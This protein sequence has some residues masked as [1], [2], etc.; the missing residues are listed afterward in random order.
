MNPNQKPWTK[1]EFGKK[2]SWVARM[3][4]TIDPD[5]V[6]LQE[7]WHAE[8]METVLARAALRDRYD[9]L[10]KP[11][12]GSKIV[13]AALV[14]KGLLRGTP[15]W[16]STFPKA[17]RL[18]STRRCGSTPRTAWTRSPRASAC[19]SPGSHGRCCTSRSRCAT[20]RRAPRCSWRT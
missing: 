17:V 18:D 8:A 13:C 5:I 6:G 15:K 3:L 10:A 4:D 20:T 16:I 14:R 9:L 19:T 1:E 2:V 12:D 7:L 11:A